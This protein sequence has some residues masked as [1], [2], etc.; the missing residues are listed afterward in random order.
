MRHSIVPALLA[1]I[2]ATP[3]FAQEE[4]NLYSSRHY[5]TDEALYSDFEATTGIKINRI[6]DSADKLIERMRSEGEL[7]QADVLVTVDVG[8][9]QR[10]EDAGLFQPLSSELVVEVVP[11][12]LRDET[13]LWTGLTTRARLIFFDKDDVTD[14]P[15]TYQ[16]LADPKY[17]GMICTRSSSNVYMLSLLASIVANNG[18]EAGKEWAAGLLANLARDPEGGDTDQLRGLISGE[19]EIAVANHYYY[20][21]GVSSEVTGLSEGIDKI[22]IVFPNQETTGTHINLSAAGIAKYAPHEENARAF[23]EYLL[24]PRAQKLLA[25][26]NNE[27]PVVA[28]VELSP[29]LQQ[30]G[31]FRHDPIRIAEFGELSDRAQEIYNEVGYK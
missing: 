6:E 2:V 8:L 23:I 18:D 13:D 7:S 15:Q 30:L 29:T 12:N 5:D 1:L 25:E 22:G 20:L 16:D 10:A 4:I 19:C 11:E 14:P 27:F 31:D 28:G 3:A 26:G 24:S 17:K 21:R 9:I